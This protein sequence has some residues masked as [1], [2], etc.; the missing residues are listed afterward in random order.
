MSY[1]YRQQSSLPQVKLKASM[2]FQATALV[3]VC[4]TSLR[5]GVLARRSYSAMLRSL[6]VVQNMSGSA[7]LNL[8]GV[9]IKFHQEK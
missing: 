4:M 1:V 3:R 8:H 9:R 5:M 2:G 6:P 7:G